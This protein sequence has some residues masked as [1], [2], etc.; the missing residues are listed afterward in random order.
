MAEFR[1]VVL[2]DSD[3]GGAGHGLHTMFADIPDVEV[4]GLADPDADGRERLAAECGAVSTYGDYREMLTAERAD[5]AILGQGWYDEERVGKF[6]A[7]VE[8]GVRAI[9]IEKPIAAWPE[10]AD[11]MRAAARAAGVTV[12]Q[13]VRSREH[14]VMRE[15]K[16]R[17]GA[18]EWGPLM[19]VK[20]HGKGDRRAGPVDALILGVHELDAMLYIVGEHPSFC[21]GTVLSDGRPATRAAARPAAHNDIGLLAGDRLFAQY[22]FPSGVIGTYESFPV[23]D[24]SH[25]REWVGLDMYFRDALITR[26]DAPYC[27]FHLF[28]HGGVFP[29]ERM[30]AWAPLPEGAGW[31]LDPSEF[32]AGFKSFETWLADPFEAS[33]HI[34]GLELVACLREGREPEFGALDDAL[35]TL[36]MIVAPQHSHLEGR[37]VE[38]PLRAR[39]NPW[40]G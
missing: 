25:S 8:Q 27:E 35:A 10:Q 1:A 36:D 12:M 21:W 26:R 29:Q 22:T 24:G 14:P 9:L 33:N 34:L 32:P 7:A 15:I 40:T 6:L 5:I 20:A 23:G 31:E 13:P 18:G 30:G 17:A 4:S 37:R 28:P 3:K 16:Q 39:G 2:A 19:Q 11:R 38:L